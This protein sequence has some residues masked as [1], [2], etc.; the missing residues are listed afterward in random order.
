MVDK[1]RPI[2]DE[3]DVLYEFGKKVLTEPID[4]LKD[5]IKLMMPLTTGLITIYFALLEFLNKK[6]E[7][8]ITD[9]G[10]ILIPI[11]LLFS[12]FSFIVTSFPIPMKLTISNIESI[13]R[14]RKTA[15]WWKY[16]GASVGSFFFLSGFFLMIV[17]LI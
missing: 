12:L 4:I 8:G 14:Y 17:T 7:G 13:K 10:L 15:I 6:P 2:S 3:N 11:I 1:S 9:D 16:I 5:F